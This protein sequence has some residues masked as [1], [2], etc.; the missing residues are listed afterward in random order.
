VTLVGKTIRVSATG[1][2]LV[3]DAGGTPVIV[4]KRTSLRVIR[5][6]LGGVVVGR[7]VR[8]RAIKVNGKLYALALEHVAGELP[9]TR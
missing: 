4:T 7:T 2:Y 3:I 9:P 5:G 1:H 8:V 6:G